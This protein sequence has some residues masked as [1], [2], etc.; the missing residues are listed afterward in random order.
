MTLQMKGLCWSAGIHGIFLLVLVLMQSFAAM[1]QKITVIDFTLSGEQA[2]PTVRQVSP[3]PKAI[4]MKSSREAPKRGVRELPSLSAE[5]LPAK[6]DHPAPAEDA[7]AEEPPTPATHAGSNRTGAAKEGSDQEAI[8]RLAESGAKAGS[9]EE[10]R[11]VYLKEHFTYIRDRIMRGILYPETARKMGW[12]GQVKIAFV[13]SE[14]GGVDDIRVVAS[15]GFG[16]LDRNA[17]DTVKKAAPFPRPPVSAEI[18]MAVTYR[19][20]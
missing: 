15:S 14:D 4:M 8:D 3:P 6:D 18:R 9:P 12:Y 13:V 7:D 2:P 17:V 1:P 10:S 11:A 16:E 19:L 20:N 5:A